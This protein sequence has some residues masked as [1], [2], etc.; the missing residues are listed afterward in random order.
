MVPEVRVASLS[1]AK[2]KQE[3]GEKDML[4]SPESEREM[5]S[6]QSHP[7]ED[8]AAVDDQDID[9]DQVQ[10]L[11]GTG[12]PDDVGEVDVDPGEINLDAQPDPSVE[13]SGW[14]DR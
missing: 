13:N 11:P 3:P 2:N 14:A 4:Y 8:S 12:G 5:Q 6:M 10:V 9:A 7:V 1:M